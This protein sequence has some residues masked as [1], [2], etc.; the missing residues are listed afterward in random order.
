MGF[1]DKFFG[2]GASYPPLDDSN[3]AARQMES[4]RRDIEALAEQL[5]VPIEVVPAEDKAYI[6][7]GKPP[8]EFG[9]FWVDHGQV[10]NLKKLVD[11][12]G[13]SHSETM[14]L[15]EHLR[16]AYIHSQAEQR[17]S[18][19]TSKGKVTVT[20]SQSLLNEVQKI[21]QQDV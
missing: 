7:A 1:F 16:E 17:F 12:K 18:A 15:S 20:P 11:E 3:P 9:L 14:K 8:K 10:G 19:E 6:F 13:L 2:I 21:I 5:Q 4:L